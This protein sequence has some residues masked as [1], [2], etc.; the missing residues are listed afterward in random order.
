MPLTVNLSRTSPWGKFRHSSSFD[1]LESE[2]NSSGD[3]FQCSINLNREIKVIVRYI[4]PLSGELPQMYLKSKFEDSS[5]RGH[6]VK[7]KASREI[8][9][10]VQSPVSN[11]P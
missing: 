5:R 2:L 8:F 11:S 9:L 7:A 10:Y 1:Y 6:L 3:F 4:S